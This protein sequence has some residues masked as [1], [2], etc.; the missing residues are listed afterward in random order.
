MAAVASASPSS[1]L[2]RGMGYLISPNTPGSQGSLSSASRVRPP[3]LNVVPFESSDVSTTVSIPYG[4]YMKLIHINSAYQAAK[5]SLQG[6]TKELVQEKH[7]I[8][9]LSHTIDKLRKELSEMQGQIEEEQ[10]IR[11][12]LEA[13][14]NDQNLRINSQKVQIQSLR[15][16]IR[17]LRENSGSS[18][19][20]DQSLVGIIKLGPPPR[21][22]L[23]STEHSLSVSSHMRIAS[24]STLPTVT[25]PNP[26]KV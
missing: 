14:I 23:S 13:T 10:G 2:T 16:K 24:P 15:E 21:K 17:R 8:L 20:V 4:E 19:L 26:T 22:T 12:R 25:N 5:I 9:S 11:A 18:R 6:L 7:K 1:L 3:R